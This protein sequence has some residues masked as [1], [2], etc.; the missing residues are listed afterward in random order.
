MKLLICGM[1]RDEAMGV[2]IQSFYFFNERL[3]TYWEIILWRCR[4]WSDM[5]LT[6]RNEFITEALL[7]LAK[8]IILSTFHAAQASNLCT[9]VHPI[10]TYWWE[11]WWEARTAWIDSLMTA[12]IMSN[13]NLPHTSMHL[14]WDHLL[15]WPTLPCPEVSSYPLVLLI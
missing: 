15:I 11:L 13:P 8:Q 10:P 4:T 14:L 1:N 5:V 3:I 2:L 7:F 12:M 9:A 6:I